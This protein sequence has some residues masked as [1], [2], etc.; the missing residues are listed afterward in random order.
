MAR[1]DRTANDGPEAA[2]WT[3]ADAAMER[4]AAGDDE[5]FECV[6]DVLA[7]FLLRYLRRRVN[8]EDLAQDLLQDTLLHLHRGRGTFITGAAVLPW[9]YAIARRLLCDARRHERRSVPVVEIE[10]ICGAQEAGGEHSPEEL[11]IARQIC[12]C[13]NRS[14]EE[15][16]T[17]Q[18][19]A[20]TLLRVEGASTRDAAL[21]LG[22]TVTAVKLRAHRAYE[23]LRRSMRGDS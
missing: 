18:R 11:L 14:L 22:T 20:F 13:V 9:S 8:R 15:M 19:T 10:D 23:A 3:P 12:D 1:Y 7:P 4:Y 21:Q 5:A 16:P 6:Y 17:L 2:A